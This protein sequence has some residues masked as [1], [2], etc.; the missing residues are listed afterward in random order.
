[1]TEFNDGD[2]LM[3]YYN[4]VFT[5]FMVGP[6]GEP[7]GSLPRKNVDTGG[8]LERTAQLLQKVPSAYDT[9]L[10][11]PILD[12]AQEVTSRKY[13]ADPKA[14]ISLR[15]LTEHARSAMF[16][17]GDGVLPSNEG[18]GYVLRRLMRRAIRHAKILGIDDPVM[19]PLVDASIDTMGEAYPEL[20]Q[21]RAY[22]TH[23]AAAEEEHFRGTLNRGLTILDL[24]I[25]DS[26][27]TLSGDVA[28]KLHDTFGFPLELTLEIAQEAGLDVDR[29]SFET[30][31]EEQRVRARGARKI[32]ERAATG[33]REVLTEVGASSFTG[34]EREA[35]EAKLLGLVKG[36]ERVPAAGEGDEVEVVL[37]QTPFYP[38]GGGQVGDRGVIEIN[39]AL[40]EVTD[41]QRVLGD[42]IVHSGRVTRGEV[43]TGGSGV[44][45]VDIDHRR[46]TMRS[47]TATHILHAILR[48]ALGEHAR[49]AGSLVEPGR[50]RF[51]FTHFERVPREVLEQVELTVNSHLLGDEGVR[52]Y[53]TT[54]DEARNR[55]AVML[56]EEKYGDIV[57]VVEVGDYSIELCG[58][59]HVARTSQIGAVR[60]LGEASIGSNLRRIEA[61]TGA[62]ALDDF[63]RSRAVLEHIALLLK[64][65]P[66]EAPAKVERLLED[67]KKAE[68]KEKA[69]QAAG[70]LEQVEGL[71]AK[72]QPS[73][74]VHVVVERTGDLNVGDLQKL[75]AAV[76]DKLEK[77][78]GPAVVVLGAV[79]NGRAALVAVTSAAYATP[80]QTIL[81]GPAQT[82]G[83]RPGGK[84][85]LATAVGSAADSLD[86]ALRTVRARIA[87]A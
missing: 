3:E 62:E 61:L 86:E 87:G 44:A 71:V 5:E 65:T 10:F 1:M 80:P 51:D 58:G 26:E 23:A 52:A 8:G 27:E 54:M 14:D 72:S 43:E 4:L 15:I 13:G 36:G 16:L 82:I 85:Q 55:G 76:R 66:E 73:G 34:Y 78:Q 21:Q 47:H 45:R 35:D 38:E 18:R 74:D 75:A 83:G 29:E 17:I 32:G 31:M 40:I 42:L 6:D 28:F 56:F 53:E 2:D 81:D 33:L 57:R 39:G 22:I 41:T 49:Q 69:R 19:E 60:V 84:G 70:T 63:R 30:L 25:K 77:L 12:R 7:V 24:A 9:D 50:L 67:L 11:K 20:A 79:S 59:T 46:S 48:D 37:D 64:S 68:H